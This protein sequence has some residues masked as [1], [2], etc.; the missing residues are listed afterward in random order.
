[1]LRIRR[2]SVDILRHFVGDRQFLVN[3]I[4]SVR[5]PLDRPSVPALVWGKQN[6][7]HV[8][9]VVLLTLLAWRGEED[10]VRLSNV[11]RHVLGR[12]HEALFN[13]LRWIERESHKNPE[14]PGTV[15]PLGLSADSASPVAWPERLDLNMHKLRAAGVAAQH[16][17]IRAVSEGHDSSVP[18]PTQLGRDEELA[19]G[20]PAVLVCHVFSPQP[21]IR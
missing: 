12:D 11:F 8:A 1:V 2:A 15:V 7:P 13:W 18:A 5:E 6:I 14:E 19:C 16:V 3:K 10:V 17:G 21:V 9:V 4:P 20:A